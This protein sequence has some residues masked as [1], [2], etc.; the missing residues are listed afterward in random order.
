MRSYTYICLH[1]LKTCLYKRLQNIRKSPKL[2]ACTF[3]LKYYVLISKFT[4][5]QYLYCRI[6][7]IILLSYYYI[8]FYL[9]IYFITTYYSFSYLY[10][11]RKDILFLNNGYTRTSIVKTKKRESEKEL[12][13]RV[14]KAKPITHTH[15]Y[16]IFTRY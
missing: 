7:I 12:T 1:I 13:G 14:Q 3:L 4:Y 15:A 8:L 16:N 11:Y 6:I 5:L 2:Y 9:F 10:Y